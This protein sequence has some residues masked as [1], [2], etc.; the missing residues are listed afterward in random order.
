ML[1]AFVSKNE[2]DLVIDNEHAVDW[3]LASVYFI[4][5]YSLVF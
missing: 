4:L 2:T 3:A 1:V 5:S